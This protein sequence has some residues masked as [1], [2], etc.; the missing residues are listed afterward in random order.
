MYILQDFKNIKTIKIFW[1][2]IIG[3]A[4]RA[5]FLFRLSSW[6]LNH[7]MR[8]FSTMFW[9]L[10]IA[11]HSCDITPSA[12]IGSG[13]SIAHSVGI[14]IGSGVVAGENFQIYQNVTIGSR[15]SCEYPILGDN[16]ILYAGCAILGGIV[17]GDN[18]KVGANSVV[19]NDVP[20]NSTAIGIPAK[21]FC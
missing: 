19:I 12:K 3:N 14:V 7:H 4:Y 1:S 6:F 5:V 18:A 21:I 13:F 10:N 8:V 11:L 17:I 16:V 2:L 15:D 20:D 9:S